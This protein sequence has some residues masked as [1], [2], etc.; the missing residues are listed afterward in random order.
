MMPQNPN[1]ALQSNA[2][3]HH[4]RANTKVTLAGNREQSKTAI[5]GSRNENKMQL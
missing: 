4:Q 5:E 2:G 3:N 1:I